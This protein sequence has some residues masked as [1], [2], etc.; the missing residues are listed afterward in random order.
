MYAQWKGESVLTE[1][2]ALSILLKEILENI[3][4]WGEK[5]RKKKR[6]L[7]QADLKPKGY[8]LTA[9]VTSQSLATP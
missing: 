6:K 1:M 9:K 4:L 3:L 5:K 7:F 2:D 8:Y